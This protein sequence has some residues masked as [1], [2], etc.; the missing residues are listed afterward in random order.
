MKSFV[1][2]L[3]LFFAVI[4]DVAGL[5][6]H[7]TRA[8]VNECITTHDIHFKN[9]PDMLSHETPSS[10]KGRQPCASFAGLDLHRTRHQTI[11]EGTTAVTNHN[12]SLI[13]R[14]L[15]QMM[16]KAHAKAS[17]DHHKAAKDHYKAEAVHV[18]A[19]KDHE[20]AG[21][22]VVAYDST[23]KAR[24]HAKAALALVSPRQTSI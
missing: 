10:Y 11:L 6:T 1:I 19:A 9:V 18:A 3:I 17:N 12:D 15:E 21:R 16:K 4:T 5:P 24:E 22:Y 20:R 23:Q 13:Q 8:T 7:S 14:S 2:F